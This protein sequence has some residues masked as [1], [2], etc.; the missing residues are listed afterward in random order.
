[1]FKKM[2]SKPKANGIALI[3]F[4]I[5]VGLYL[6]IG[7]SLTLSGNKQGFYAVPASISVIVGIIAA[8]FL[9]KG[10]INDK[11][12]SLVAGCGDS[13]IIIMLLIFLLAGAFGQVTEKIG[14]VSS[15][16]NLGLS[17][18]P[19]RFLV[20]GV[21]LISCFVC[22]AIG[23]SMGT[24]ATIAPICVTLASKTGISMPLLLAALIGG[25][26]FGNNMSIIADTGIV[27]TRMLHIEIRDKFKTNIKITGLAV[28][29]TTLL[30]FFFGATNNG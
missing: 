30:Y 7:I 2:S 11:F 13:N 21:F 29:C 6:L 12:N 18:V 9:C 4:L 17:L 20:P 1:M 25:A 28:I 16:V 10:S 5:F 22:L 24:I 23:T 3:P 19:F 14:G 8:F 26:M 15:T 27:I